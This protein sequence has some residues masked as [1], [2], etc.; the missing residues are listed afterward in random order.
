VVG[1]GV[2]TVVVGGVVVAGGVTGV[3]VHPATRIARNAQIIRPMAI[4]F[5][6][7]YRQ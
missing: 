6:L 4:L 2:L 1:T 3:V 7:G 5:I